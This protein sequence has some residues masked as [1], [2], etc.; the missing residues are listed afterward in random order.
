METWGDCLIIDTVLILGENKKHK[1]T[2]EIIEDHKEDKVP[3]Y[4]VSVIGS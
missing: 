4:L 1:V 3:F 2:I